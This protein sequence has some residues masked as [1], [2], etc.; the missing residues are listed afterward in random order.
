M[1]SPWFTRGWR[2]VEL[3]LSKKVKVLSKGEFE[4]RPQ[5]V[6]LEDILASDPRT[7]TRG[8]WLISQLTQRL[9]QPVHN[10]GDLLAILSQRIT[11]WQKDRAEI[12]AISA[13]LADYDF[14]GTAS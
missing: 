9:R 1:V 12:S 7:S 4:D 13:G 6:D 2:A 8:H 11:L 14:E 3:A 10:V 5:V